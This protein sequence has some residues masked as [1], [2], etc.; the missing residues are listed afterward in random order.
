MKTP[1]QKAWWLVVPVVLLVAFN[2]L[3]P[4]ITLGLSGLA[5][6]RVPAASGL[7]NFAR[8]TAGSFGTSIV[9]TWW[10]RRASLHHAQ[11]A[12]R[13]SAYDPSSSQAL[14]RMQADGMS[15]QQSYEAMNRMID[16]QAFMLSAN[17]IFWVSAIVFVLLIGLIW[18]A[19]PT[20]SGAAAEAAT[21]AH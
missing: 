15:V 17:D 20:K 14:A 7:F 5:P 13:I 10:D 6:D 11:L 1:N 21:A 8:I 9:T 18:L 4:L 3:I 12:E 2:A 19:R 16:Q